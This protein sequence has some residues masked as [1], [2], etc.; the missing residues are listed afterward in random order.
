MCRAGDI[1]KLVD[2]TIVQ[3]KRI[4]ITDKKDVYEMFLRY[5]KDRNGYLGSENIREICKKLHLPVDNDVI[6]EVN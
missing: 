2:Q 3:M 6:Q 1:D 4:G 5:N